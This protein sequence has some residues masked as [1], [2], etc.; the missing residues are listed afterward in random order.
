MECTYFDL[1][2]SAN[3]QYTVLKTVDVSAE[4]GREAKFRRQFSDMTMEGGSEDGRGMESEDYEDGGDEVF[5]DGG[6]GED[7]DDPYGEAEE[8]LDGEGNVKMSRVMCRLDLATLWGQEE[9]GTAVVPVGTVEFPDQVMGEERTNPVS[10]P[11]AMEPYCLIQAQVTLNG[12]D[13]SKPAATRLLCHRFQ[14]DSISPTCIRILTGGQVDI[15]GEGFFPPGCL[16]TWA[17]LHY[18]GDPDRENLEPVIEETPEDLVLR[19]EYISSTLMSFQVP[20]LPEILG[21]MLW[22]HVQGACT[23]E[24]TVQFRAGGDVRGEG[25][26]AISDCTLPLFY[27][28]SQPVSVTPTLDR[29]VGGRTLTIIKRS[30]EGFEFRSDNPKV[31]F[32]LP[33]PAEPIYVEA[34]MVPRTVSEPVHEP[35]RE[36]VL[37]VS[38]SPEKTALA[39]AAKAVE[40]TGHGTDPEESAVEAN[41][42]DV[43]PPRT[44]YEIHCIFPSLVLDSIP[45]D[46]ESVPQSRASSPG[47]NTR[48]SSTN[49]S[50]ARHRPS[51]ELPAHLSRSVMVGV[52]FDGLTEPEESHC[53]KLSVYDNLLIK[54]NPTVP[55]GGAFQLNSSVSLSVEGLVPSNECVVRLKGT[56][57]LYAEA[58]GTV[59]CNDHGVG[60]V[61]FNIPSSLS[62]LEPE[63]KGRTP[64]YQVEISLDGGLTFD[65]SENAFLPVKEK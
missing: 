50:P 60:H 13:F 14:V 15:H 51:V 48:R 29:R 27:V 34:T 43:T 33:R 45:A 53:V 17:V 11:L 42:A 19:V 54:E 8:G 1:E 38:G 64:L 56:N 35:R 26:V 36:S 9:K 6:G 59:Q 58:K 23:V 16:P 20:P 30:G 12:Y 41:D 40:A 57:E 49:A 18:I 25:S 47:N 3:N 55:K 22:A 63:M 21:D 10:K 32:R 31:V 52:L 61:S 7:M 24:M 65:S 46:E 44:R 2:D 62:G 28:E 5:R 39:A 4:S 37:S